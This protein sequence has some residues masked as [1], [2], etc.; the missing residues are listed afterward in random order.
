MLTPILSA[1]DT[2]QKWVRRLPLRM[3]VFG[4]VG[5]I[6]ANLSDEA[7]AA[8]LIFLGVGSLAVLS[9]LA[10]W[11]TVLIASG[12][13]GCFGAWTLVDRIDEWEG[14]PNLR[15]LSGWAR[16]LAGGAGALSIT[17]VLYVLIILI[18]PLQAFALVTVG[19]AARLGYLSLRSRQHLSD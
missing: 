18:G 10:D 13:A 15:S 5:S 11:Q 1:L 14:D 16:F 7:L 12:L 17:A 8:L 19:G 3:L 4:Y 9:W 6:L 2:L